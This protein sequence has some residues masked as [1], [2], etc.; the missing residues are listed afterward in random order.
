MVVPHPVLMPG[1]V[2]ARIIAAMITRFIVLSNNDTPLIFSFEGLQV[3]R[4]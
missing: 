3:I 1:A 4:F 2:V